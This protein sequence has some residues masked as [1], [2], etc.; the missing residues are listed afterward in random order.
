MERLRQNLCSHRDQQVYEKVADDLEHVWTELFGFCRKDP[1]KHEHSAERSAKAAKLWGMDAAAR[2][3]QMVWL[4]RLRVGLETKASVAS[5]RTSLV[6]SHEAQPTVTRKSMKLAARHYSLHS[7]V[8][9]QLSVQGYAAR[10]T[11]RSGLV[12]DVAA[13]LGKGCKKAFFRDNEAI[14]AAMYLMFIE[15]RQRHLAAWEIDNLMSQVAANTRMMKAAVAAATISLSKQGLSQ[16]EISAVDEE[17]VRICKRSQQPLQEKIKQLEGLYHCG[18]ESPEVDEDD[19]DEEEIEE[20]EMPAWAAEEEMPAWEAEEEYKG[21]LEEEYMGELLS[22]SV[23]VISEAEEELQ[24]HVKKKTQSSI[25]SDLREVEALKK[26]TQSPVMSDLQEVEA[27]ADQQPDGP[28]LAAAPSALLS[29]SSETSRSDSIKQPSVSSQQCSAPAC[30]ELVEPP[31]AEPFRF[32]ARVPLPPTKALVTEVAGLSLGLV[33]AAALNAVDHFEVDAAGAGSWQLIITDVRPGAV[34]AWNA[35]PSLGCRVRAGDRIVRVHVAGRSGVTELGS[36][37]DELLSVA[38]ASLEL[39][40]EPRTSREAEAAVAAS[41]PVRLPECG[42]DGLLEEHPSAR[43][44]FPDVWLTGRSIASFEAWESERSVMTS[45]PL[46]ASPAR[47]DELHAGTGGVTRLTPSPLP[48]GGP[49]LEPA[50]SLS[51]SPA[52]PMSL[53]A[54]DAL[55]ARQRSVR[56]AKFHGELPEWLSPDMFGPCLRHAVCCLRADEVSTLLRDEAHTGVTGAELWSELLAR[57]AAHGVQDAG[58]LAASAIPYLELLWRIG[59]AA[60]DIECRK[61]QEHSELSFTRSLAVERRWRINLTAQAHGWCLRNLDALSARGGSQQK[62][63][64]G[65]KAKLVELDSGSQAL[66]RNLLYARELECTEDSARLQRLIARRGELCASPLRSPEPPDGPVCRGREL[67]KPRAAT[68]Y[69][70]YSAWWHAGASRHEAFAVRKPR[71]SQLPPASFRRGRGLRHRV[72]V[73]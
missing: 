46:A 32:T 16:A 51:L 64:S 63:N 45:P 59:I 61:L 10:P 54:A 66:L 58:D 57:A 69:D 19:E 24:A 7:N 48:N 35:R 37:V 44:D 52:D 55:S 26:K 70:S 17:V 33:A 47:P 65:A 20:E 21:E 68:G 73:T 42:E 49:R 29:P 28:D 13:L 2:Q 30:D 60:L 11:G 72:V 41:V 12:N 18:W 62:P 23:A 38:A 71:R 39:E 53:S 40:L 4:Q 31:P 67:P 1:N 6:A 34:W 50:A 25:V 5:A 22:S 9:A 27:E 3:L 36:M 15:Y 43:E 14:T 56:H 8:S